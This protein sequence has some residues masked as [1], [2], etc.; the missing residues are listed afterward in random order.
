[1]LLLLLAGAYN[2]I[3]IGM[4]NQGA[5]TGI[6]MAVMYA[7][8]IPMSAAMAMIIAINLSKAILVEGSIDGLITLKE[9]EEEVEF[10]DVRKTP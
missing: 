2:I 1:V 7:A 3:P 6:P 10:E 9:S 8:V 5:S 4:M